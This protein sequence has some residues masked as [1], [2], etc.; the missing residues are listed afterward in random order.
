MKKIILILL[1]LTLIL[2]PNVAF[3]EQNED[4]KVVE[5]LKKEIEKA[6]QLEHNIRPHEEVADEIITSNLLL[7]F[8]DIATKDIKRDGQI[9][10][11]EAVIY[12]YINNGNTKIPI[13]EKT[14]GYLILKD[15]SLLRGD[16]AKANDF[17]NK[18]FKNSQDG[19][20]YYADLLKK[21]Q[22]SPFSLYNIVVFR[23]FL[24]EIFKIEKANT[25]EA[26]AETNE[27][28]QVLMKEDE[29]ITSR[30]KQ[31]ANVSDRWDKAITEELEPH[32][33]YPK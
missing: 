16:K 33:G 12:G 28:V 22:Y 6:K 14:F 5:A 27:A 4:T 17:F 20:A 31:L 19:V 1:T 23:L 7:S 32:K 9:D 2:I 8:I 21:K 24:Q 25:P 15:L 13:A 3:V 10:F 26:K 11:M 18:A 30:F 29:L